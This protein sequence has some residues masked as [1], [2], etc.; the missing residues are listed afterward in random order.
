MSRL[1][2]EDDGSG[3]KPGCSPFE[4]E[5]ESF[6]LLSSKLLEYIDFLVANAPWYNSFSALAM[7]STR[8]IEIF[9]QNV[10]SAKELKAVMERLYA[11]G[12]LQADLSTANS[13]ASKKRR[14]ELIMQ[15]EGE[16]DDWEARRDEL[17]KQ[18]DTTQTATAA[19]AGAGGEGQGR[20][21]RRRN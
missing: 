17:R 15:E 9:H 8:D 5:F 16:E 12:D 11:S 19:A 4:A 13:S 14:R 18:K 1:D 7:D 10:K 3:C 6:N 21:G 2:Y 20:G